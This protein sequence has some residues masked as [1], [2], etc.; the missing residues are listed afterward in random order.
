[1]S[2]VTH[3]MSF[4]RD[5]VMDRGKIIETGPPEQVFVQPEAPWPQQFLAKVPP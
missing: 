1:M 4:V 2:I 3:E 5:V